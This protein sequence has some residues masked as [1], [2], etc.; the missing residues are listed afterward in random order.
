MS[1]IV[2]CTILS[3]GTETPHGYRLAHFEVVKHVNKISRAELSFWD[4]ETSN[5]EYP[6][7]DSGDFD[8]GKK[9]T[10]K[11]RY[12]EESGSDVQV[13]EGIVTKIRHHENLQGNFLKVTLKDAAI[14]M[15]A[16]PKTRY[17]KE[18]TDDKIITEI[19]GD[20]AGVTA[21]TLETTKAE[22]PCQIQHDQTDWDFILD[23]ADENG[24]FVVLDDGTFN[25]QDP[26]KSSGTEHEF[27][28]GISNVYHF[29]FQSNCENLLQEPQAM[30]WDVKQ[31]AMSAETPALA[32][33]MEAG[34][35][36]PDGI[37]K[38]FQKEKAEII[39]PYHAIDNELEAIATGHLRRRFASWMVGTITVD[40]DGEIKVGDALVLVGYPKIFNNK[41]VITGVSHVI[42]N[43]GWKTTIQVGVPYE[44]KK[45]NSQGSK[46]QSLQVGVV[47]SFE[48][49]PEN[50]YR[51][52]VWLPY[53]KE[54][55]SLIWA[56]MA[57]PEAGNLRGQVWHPEKGDEVIVGFLGGNIQHAVIVGSMYNPINKEP[58]GFDYS[59]ENTLR[60]IVTKEGLKM[61]WDDENKSIKLETS[62]ENYIE[63]TE[64]GLTIQIAKFIKAESGDE[65]SIKSTKDTTIIS[66]AA[67]TVETSK[68][69]TFTI[70]G[71][72]S[73]EASQDVSINGSSGT[74]IEGAKIDVEASGVVN[75]KGSAINLN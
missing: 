14:E 24:L 31:Q 4:G 25:M 39:K 38:E 10:L 72:L 74:K 49:D 62:E 47:G 12:E 55:T 21:G 5:Q 30:S 75:V 67:L 15:G 36:Q 3:D 22:F 19:L 11:V 44:Q 56:R 58:E 48:A 61:T 27:E 59:E 40:G 7:A 33:A 8:T 70:G 69:G 57:H 1:G 26:F 45:N 35:T 9:V 54:E 51:I 64:E 73:A 71:A 23:R 53:L 41:M 18:K 66:D 20:Y 17:F 34:E 68:D 65:V 42:Q 46:A 16:T 2:T 43:N 60:G 37:A 32:V 52:P 63:L 13:F 6:I 50:M 28:K 29:D